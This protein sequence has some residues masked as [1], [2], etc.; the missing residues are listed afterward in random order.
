MHWH[1]CPVLSVIRQGQDTGGITYM[2]RR[3]QA[4][5]LACLLRVSSGHMF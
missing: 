4:D 2:R 3:G 5:G 1:W